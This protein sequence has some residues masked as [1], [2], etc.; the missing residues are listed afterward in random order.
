MEEAKL[1]QHR[2]AVIVDALARQPVID[3][4]RVHR[5]KRELHPS[6]RRWQAAPRA[7]MRTADRDFQHQA[8]GSR[9]PVLHFYC[10]I[11]HRAHE[12]AVV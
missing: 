10:Q 8:L 6:A 11:G 12:L 7:E 4:E 3:V 9:V 5:A 1:A 2:S